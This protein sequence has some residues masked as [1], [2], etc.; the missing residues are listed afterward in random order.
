MCISLSIPDYLQICFGEME[1]KWR[2]WRE[3]TQTMVENTQSHKP[4]AVRQQHLLPQRHAAVTNTV[5]STIGNSSLSR[6]FV[7][8]I[9]DMLSKSPFP[10][11]RKKRK[12]AVELCWMLERQEVLMWNKLFSQ[13]QF[14]LNRN[15]VLAS[16][17]SI[18]KSIILI[19]HGC[20]KTLGK[21]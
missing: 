9:M 10:L 21:E 3:P 20:H 19:L 2:T 15:S 13:R 18:Y 7:K 5:F 12:P 8:Y 11:L 16:Q 1:R 17:T 4:G 14:F 6:T